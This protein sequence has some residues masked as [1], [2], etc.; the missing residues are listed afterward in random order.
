MVGFV[1]GKPRSGMFCVFIHDVT[2]RL[3]YLYILHLLKLLA[4]GAAL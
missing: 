1:G 3:K 2:D 4:T